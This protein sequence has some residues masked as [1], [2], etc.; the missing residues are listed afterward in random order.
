MLS[1][2]RVNGSPVCCGNED[3][4]RSVTEGNVDDELIDG[5]GVEAVL[6][7][8]LGDPDPYEDAHARDDHHRRQA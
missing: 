6:S 4:D 8:E 2:Q 3:A 5:A 7:K 1:K